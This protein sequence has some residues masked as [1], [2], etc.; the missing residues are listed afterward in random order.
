[1]LFF[2]IK[3]VVSSIVDNDVLVEVNRCILRLQQNFQDGQ[4]SLPDTADVFSLNNAPSRRELIDN[5]QGYQDTCLLT[6]EC[7]EI[8][9]TDALG[10][11]RM[12]LSKLTSRNMHFRQVSFTLP[13]PTIATLAHR[14]PGNSF[15]NVNTQ[16][17]TLVS[18]CLT[19]IKYRYR[20]FRRPHHCELAN[21]TIGRG[22][23]ENSST[24]PA[25]WGN[26]REHKK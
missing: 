6:N 24:T 16:T 3:T 19:P 9:I 2:A 21:D 12:A 4:P 13:P 8:R 25:T 7:E 5:W 26:E 23:I 10:R 15:A 11:S 22:I 20:N 17:I 18:G 1:M 14:P